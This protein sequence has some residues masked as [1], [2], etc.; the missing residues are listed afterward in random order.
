MGS[1]EIL[2]N[3]EARLTDLVIHGA[4]PRRR[5]YDARRLPRESVNAIGMCNN[6][7]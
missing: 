6:T 5:R 4:E 1:E 2:V 7:Y 3:A